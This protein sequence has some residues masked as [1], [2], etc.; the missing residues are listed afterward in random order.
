MSGRRTVRV[1]FVSDAGG[2]PPAGAFVGDG[3]EGAA[4][5]VGHGGGGERGSE[6]AG[7]GEGGVLFVGVAQAEEGYVGVAG[8]SVVKT[9]GDGEVGRV[10]RN[11][12]DGV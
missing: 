8:E 4:A 10:S 5:E 9:I 6:G 3:G 12:T 1:P 11:L 2:V 7:G